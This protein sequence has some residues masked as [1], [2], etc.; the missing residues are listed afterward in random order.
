MGSIPSPRL[1]VEEMATGEMPQQWGTRLNSAFER[2]EEAI[3]GVAPITVTGNLALTANNFTPD[4]ARMGVLNLIG[5]PATAFTITIPAVEKTY[6]VRNATAQDGT[7]KTAT[8]AGAVVRAGMLTKAVCLGTDTYAADPRLNQIKAPN[9]PVSLGNQKVT[10]LADGAAGT[11]DAVPMSQLQALMVDVL[12]GGEQALANYLRTDASQSFTTAQKNLGRANLAA[13][14]LDS[15]SFTGPVSAT[16]A[17]KVGVGQIASIVEMHD[18]DSGPRFVYHNGDQIG[19]LGVDSNWDFWVNDAGQVWT[20]Q[21]GD[22]NS[23]IEA[24]AVAYGSEQGRYWANQINGRQVYA[25]DYGNDW[26][27]GAG[28]WEPHNGASVTG[29]ATTLF[30]GAYIVTGMRFRFMQLRNIDGIWY[31]MGW[32]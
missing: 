19:F 13:A 18:T 28:Y 30:S 24:R 23:R 21:F 11:R 2:V 6:W 25:A 8:G 16:G 10:D 9:G 27:N 4:Q 31:T 7:I 20:R 26:A 14:P 32:G 3:A 15:P 22:L 17:L 1:R 5:A 12:S 29:R